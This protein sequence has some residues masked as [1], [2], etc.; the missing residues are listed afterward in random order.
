MEE[1]A[2]AQRKRSPVPE[3][4]GPDP[5]VVRG[6]GRAHLAQQGAGA[7]AGDDPGRAQSALV[8][9]VSPGDGRNEHTAGAVRGAKHAPGVPRQ[10]VREKGTHCGLSGK[11][12]SYYSAFFIPP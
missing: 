9:G 10:K 12:Q 2:A 7:I 11:T 4:P 1:G 6:P 5:E 8:G 3:Q